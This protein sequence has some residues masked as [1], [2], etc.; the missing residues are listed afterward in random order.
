MS[1]VTNVIVLPGIQACT[2]TPYDHERTEQLEKLLL[3]VCD[4]DDDP[5][6]YRQ[7]LHNIAHCNWPNTPPGKIIDGRGG[8][9]AWGGSKVPE[10]DVY[11]AAFNHLNWEKFR[12]WIES[13]PWISRNQVLVLVKGESDRSF[14]VWQ[15]QGER[16][17]CALAADQW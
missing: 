16:L 15:F 1:V 8:G 9:Q 7:G 17:V 12:S 5:F 3:S 13:L 6:A 4:D 10:C 14:S 11:A 2:S